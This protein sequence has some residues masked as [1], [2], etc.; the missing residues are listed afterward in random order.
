MGK[1]EQKKIMLVIYNITTEKAAAMPLLLSPRKRKR[2]P[3][4][5]NLLTKQKPSHQ[6]IKVRVSQIFVMGFKRS[7]RK[8]RSHL[9]S[10]FPIFIF[11]F[12]ERENIINTHTSYHDSLFSGL[13]WSLIFRGTSPSSAYVTAIPMSYP[14]N[15]AGR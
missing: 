3:N 13:S 15:L 1:H 4:T 12:F 7:K 8:K 5:T 9:K 10:Y 14:A 2:N 11:F 6:Q